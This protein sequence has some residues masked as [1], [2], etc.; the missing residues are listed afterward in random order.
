M[1]YISGPTLMKRLRDYQNAHALLG[2]NTEESRERFVERLVNSE[3]KLRALTIRKFAGSDDPH[4]KDFHP[5]KAVVG[6]LE[7]GQHD[8]AVWLA[9]LTIHF[10]PEKKNTIREFYG[11]FGGGRWNWDSAF[12]NADEVRK[13]MAARPRNLN[14]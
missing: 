6:L 7:N 2:L 10:G 1:P 9:F 5:L 11:K 4:K 3:L 12:R 8:E 14:A 13:W